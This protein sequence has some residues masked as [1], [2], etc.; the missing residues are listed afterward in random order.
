MEA[1][2]SYLGAPKLGVVLLNLYIHH[3]SEYSQAKLEFEDG[4]FSVYEAQQGPPNLIPFQNQTPAPCADHNLNTI[5]Q[6]K[7]AI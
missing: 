6:T 2:A 1:K 7:D 3:P 4:E 5:R